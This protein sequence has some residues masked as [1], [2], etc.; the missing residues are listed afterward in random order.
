MDEAGF[1]PGC[2]KD[3]ETVIAKRVSDFRYGAASGERLESG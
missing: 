3:L 1:S 2:K